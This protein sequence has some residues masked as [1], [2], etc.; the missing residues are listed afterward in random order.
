MKYR[1]IQYTIEISTHTTSTTWCGLN[2]SYNSAARILQQSCMSYEWIPNSP[3]NW[4]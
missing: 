3:D 4:Q 1:A 2:I